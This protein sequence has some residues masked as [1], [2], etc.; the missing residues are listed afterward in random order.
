MKVSGSSLLKLLGVAADKAEKYHFQAVVLK[1]KVLK[2]DIEGFPILAN[3]GGRIFI[4]FQGYSDPVI[5]RRLMAEVFLGCSAEPY[6]GFVMAGIVYT[7][8]K[9][10]EAALPL[11]S[12]KSMGETTDCRLDGCFKEI[13]LSNY[14]QQELEA[15]DPKLSAKTNKAALLAKGH[16]WQD[17][18]RQIFPA[19]QQWEALNVL[20]LFILNRFHKLS[21]EEVTTMLN[22]DLMDTLAGQQIHDIGHQKGLIEDAREMLLEVLEERFGIVPKD[23][24]KQIRAISLRDHLKQLHRQAI[25]CPDM[26]GFKDMLSKVLS[27]QKQHN[28]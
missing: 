12:F 28:Q 6:Q 13:V 9:Y 2:P 21:Y 25:R 1:D 7:D 18:V 23:L 11:N 14:T 4:E 22:F 27:P 16:E 10:Q 17:E 19:D 5:R 8:K 24:I 26:E 15:I 3:D 20:G